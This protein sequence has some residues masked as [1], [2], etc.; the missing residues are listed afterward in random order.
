MHTITITIVAHRA[1]PRRSSQLLE[2]SRSPPRGDEPAAM[3]GEVAPTPTE[4]P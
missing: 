2:A 4:R 1:S 3:T